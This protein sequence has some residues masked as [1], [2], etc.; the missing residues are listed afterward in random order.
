MMNSTVTEEEL[1][2]FKVSESIGKACLPPDTI[3]D[4]NREVTA[5]YNRHGERFATFE[6]AEYF[7]MLP[8]TKQQRLQ[9]LRQL[10]TTHNAEDTEE[11]D[12][13]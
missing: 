12:H 6:Q 7:Y 10:T 1:D 8:L 3:E 4:F 5:F 13:S 11:A 2:T 9:L